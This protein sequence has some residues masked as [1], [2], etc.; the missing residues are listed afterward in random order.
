MKRWIALLLSLAMMP[1]FFTGCGPKNIASQ[2]NLDTPQLHVR[3]GMRKLEA[4]DLAGAESELNY[5]L[6]LDS[7]YVDAVCGIALVRAQ[8]G[9]MADALAEADK[10]MKLADNRWKVYST[11]GRVLGLAQPKDWYEDAL[12][13]FSKANS[14][15]G[16]D[17]AAKEEILY[18]DG[19][20]RMQR[21]RFSEAL[22]KLASGAF[23]LV[24]SDVV[25]PKMDGYALYRK[26]RELY[27]DLP[28][29]MMTAFH[30][31]KDHIIKRSRMEG[32]EGVIFKK[33]VDPDRL[34]RTIVE[35]V[36]PER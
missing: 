9:R 34:R 16:A 18:Y 29:L 27:P 14:L 15:A 19:L 33:P 7:R 2:S 17:Q 5:A 12:K 6:R 4:G 31:D 26:V 21:Y 35:S 11:H 36:R 8:Q 24:L 22:E 13:D 20:T 25:M 3:Q 23:D 10:A 28:V 32:L 30:Y 1:V